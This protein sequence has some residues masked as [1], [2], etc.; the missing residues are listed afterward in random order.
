VTAPCLLEQYPRWVSVQYEQPPGWGQRVILACCVA[1]V[2]LCV[3]AT[4]LGAV[5][6]VVVARLWPPELIAEPLV[7]GIGTVIG[8]AATVLTFLCTRPSHRWLGTLGICLAFALPWFADQELHVALPAA[9]AGVIR[10]ATPTRPVSMEVIR[11]T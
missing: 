9:L 3:E 11:A 10:M 1:V 6:F 8:C 7:W 4:V 5:T 2:A